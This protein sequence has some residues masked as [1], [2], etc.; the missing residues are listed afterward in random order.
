MNFCVRVSLLWTLFFICTSTFAQREASPLNHQAMK[1]VKRFPSEVYFSKSIEFVNKEVWDSVLVYSSRSLSATKNK[2][3]QDFSHYFRGEAFRKKGIF[4]Q[5][6]YEFKQVRPSFEFYFKLQLYRGEMLLEQG[7]FQKAL[8]YFQTIDTLSTSKLKSIIQLD[9]VQHNI[10]LCYFHMGNYEAAEDYLLRAVSKIEQSKD[11]NSLIASYMDLANVYK[12]KEAI[13]YFEKAYRLA[14]QYGS[15][16]LRQ[17]ASLNMAVVEENRKRFKEAVGYHKEFEAWRDSLNDQNK[18]Y[19]VAQLEKKYELDQKQKQV[20]LLETEYRLKQTER[21]MYLCAALLLFLILAFGIYFYRQNIKR[22]RIILKQKQELD[23]LNAT[24]DQLFSIVSHDLRSS[25]HA[26]GATTSTL[27]E[28]LALKEYGHLEDQLEQNSTIATNTYNM[29]DNLLHW[30]LLQTQGGYFKQE[31]HR[32]SML[33]DQV[34]Y[35]FQGVLQ[36]KGITFE[37]K[38][39]KSIK[40]FV[41]AESLKIVL[42][43]FMDNSIKFSDENS[44]I[45]IQLDSETNHS[46]RIIWEDTGKGMSEETRLKL[47]SDSVQLTKKDH[48]KIIGSGLGMSLCKSMVEKNGGTLDIWSELTIGTKMIVTLHKATTNGSN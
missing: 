44:S 1:L 23:I 21:N 18:I 36:Q 48:E 4:K 22:S 27:K 9:A 5:A 24:K 38:L 37:N 16:E 28:K 17:N 47:I 11:Y 33:V 46:V 25:V 31:E 19:E 3:I 40:V 10:G 13:M 39:P 20:R 30:A 8:T 2:D 34:V 43:N 29:L 35:N 12:D 26:L 14:K 6:L 15:F 7:E 42:R 45:S 32:L 41:D